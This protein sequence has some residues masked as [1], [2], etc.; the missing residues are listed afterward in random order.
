VVELPGPVMMHDF[1][2]TAPAWCCSTCRRCS[3][4]TGL[5][6]GEPGHLLGPRAVARASASSSARRRATSVR[7]IEVD[8]F[9]VFHFLNA[10]DDP[11]DPQ[12]IV[13]TGCRAP[14]LNTS[15]EEQA[16]DQPYRPHL[17]RWRIDPAPAPCATSRSTTVPPTSPHQRPP[18]GLAHRYGYSGRTCSWTETQAAFDG[19]IK[20]DLDAGTSIDHVYGAHHRVRRDGARSRP[21]SAVEDGGWLLNFVH[22]L[23]ADRSDVVVLDAGTLDEVARVHL[24]RRVPFGFHGSFLPGR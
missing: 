11:D 21:A 14:R 5:I 17:H 24:P 19:V 7:W 2:I 20:H 10:H 3:T 23:A 9:W 12:Q 6:A 8:P 18:H 16:L 13:V 22:D 1:V 15:F 4:S